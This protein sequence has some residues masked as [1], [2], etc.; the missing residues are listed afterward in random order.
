MT[1]TTEHHCKGAITWDTAYACPLQ[2]INGDHCSITD[3]VT[4][5]TIDLTKLQHDKGEPYKVDLRDLL[6]LSVSSSI[7]TS[8][9]FEF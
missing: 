3:E 9:P 6:I 5:I 4:G 1:Y 2:T 7:A 8:I